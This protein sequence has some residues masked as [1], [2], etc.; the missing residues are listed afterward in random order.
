MFLQPFSSMH[1]E[2]A[3]LIAADTSTLMCAALVR[4]QPEFLWFHLVQVGL[5][6]QFT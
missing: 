4:P 1:Q 2:L 3:P 5:A 6:L